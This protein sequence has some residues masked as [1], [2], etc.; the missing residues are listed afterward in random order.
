MEGKVQEVNFEEGLRIKKGAILV[1]L[2]SELLEKRLQATQASH[3]QTLSDLKKSRRDFDRAKN[4]H[5]EE[6]ISEQLYDE[7]KFNVEALD[8][9]AASLKAEVERL[10]TELLKKSIKAPFDG[11]V[12]QKHIERGEWLDTGSTV[13]TIAN[14]NVIEI[15][16]EVPEIII[17]YI[18]EGMEVKAMAIG[19]QV[20]GKVTALVPRG[21][22]STR[23]F[24][25]KI[26]VKNTLSLIEGMEARVLLPIDKKQKTLAVPRDAVIP[27][28]GQD[29]VFAVKDSKAVMIP[30]NIIGYKG[31]IAG[32]DGKGLSEGIKVV[33]K[34]NERLRDGQAVKII[35]SNLQAPNNE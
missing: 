14:D 19:E 24:P 29:V 17:R 32:V 5:E 20:T 31:M 4:L 27:V 21:D 9:K 13:A 30:V 33:V 34:G 25:V 7:K 2:G 11:I 35:N 3:E 22:I 16:A 26:S 8:K 18:K 12:I 28:F 10:E 1:N 15:V 6:L 23:T